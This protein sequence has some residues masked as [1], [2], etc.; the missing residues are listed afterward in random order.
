MPKKA[1]TDRGAGQP[2]VTEVPLSQMRKAIARLTAQSKGPVPHFYVTIVID[3]DAALKMVQ[4]SKKQ[5]TA[6][7]INHL[8]IGASARA[9]SRHGAINA[10]FAGY[11]HSHKTPP[12]VRRDNAQILVEYLSADG[13]LLAQ[14]DS[15]RLAP[16]GA[17]KPVED[18]R[19]AP[20]KTRT[21]RVRL[22]S[23]RYSGEGNDGYFAF[24]TVARRDPEPG[25]GCPDCRRYR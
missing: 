2:S 23:F 8:I 12:K 13:Q 10:A 21:I 25:G 4:E 11:V 18:K 6:L 9:L 3:M 17:W 7:T 5:A 14:F 22:V 16:V 20:A 15:G 24:C 1:A 19:T